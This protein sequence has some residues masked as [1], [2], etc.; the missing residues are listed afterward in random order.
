M[1]SW[2]TAA[3]IFLA[4]IMDVYTADESDGF[5]MMKDDVRFRGRNMTLTSLLT[6]VTATPLG[7]LVFG[8]TGKQL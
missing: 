2:P 4:L 1:Y 5:A 3:V 7:C 8:T 6:G